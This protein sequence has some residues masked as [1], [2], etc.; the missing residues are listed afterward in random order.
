MFRG[1]EVVDVNRL[2]CLVAGVIFSLVSTWTPLPAHAAKK[3]TPAPPAA[4]APVVKPKTNA[5][6]SETAQKFIER[7]HVRLDALVKS[8]TALEALHAE[9]ARELDGA[10]D[11]SEMAR[12]TIPPTWDSLQAA[13]RTEFVGLVAKM[14]QNTYVKRFKPGSPVEVSYGATKALS[15]GRMEVQTS[16]TVKKTT[17]DVNYAV[18]A[19]DGRWFVYDL[20]VD[21]ASQVQAYRKSFAKILDKEGWS[22]LITRCKKAANKKPAQ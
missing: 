7:L 3:A 11:Y 10:L 1:W 22:G 9:I 17:A 14:V 6:P 8:S 13:Q 12:Q 16:I 4:S 18:L 2:F 5:A 15:A 21:D 19:A 20:I